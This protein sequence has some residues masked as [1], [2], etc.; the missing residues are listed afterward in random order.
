MAN[1]SASH[2][3]DGR[4]KGKYVPQIR[5]HTDTPRCLVRAVRRVRKETDSIPPQVCNKI[6]TQTPQTAKRLF[7]S[8]RRPS[9]D[10]EAS[11]WLL[12]EGPRGWQPRV[13]AAAKFFPPL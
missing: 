7:S 6:C 12:P 11:K 10:I 3:L 4:R 1:V 5:R 8:N 2:S 13:Q 9:G